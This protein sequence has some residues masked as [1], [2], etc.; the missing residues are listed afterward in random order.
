LGVALRL[1]NV[2]TRT[3]EE[4]RPR[5]PGHVGVYV[6]G[7]TVYDHMHIGHARTAVSF[8]VARRWLE[9]R[10]PKVTFV[11]NVTDVD[12]KILARAKEQGISP[13]QHAAAWDAE[14]LAQTRRL[15]VRDPDHMPHVTTSIPGI[16]RFIQGI[17]ASGFAYATPQHNVYF[18]VPGYDAHAQVHLK[19]AQGRG[20]GY[21]SLSNRDF[22]EMAAGTRK[23]VESD[24]RHPADF[25]LW[26]SADAGDHPDGNWDS[27]WG[28]GRPGWHIECSFMSTDLLGDT[29]DLHGGGQDLVFPHHEN[30]IAQTQA[31]TGKAPFVNVW[32][33]SGFLNVEGEKMSKSLGNFI[34]LRQM[35]DDL[36]AKGGDPE[37]LRFYYVQTHYRSK[38]DF[39]RAG[40]EDATRAL[41]GLHRTREALHVRSQAT[42]L[43]CAD[44][45]VPLQAAAEKLRQDFSASMDDDLHTPGAL[46]ALFAFQR[47]ANR[48]LDAQTATMPLGNAAAKAALAAFE[49]CGQALTL[50]LAPVAAASADVPD[51]L[52][53]AAAS[54]GVPLD[55][56]AS[57]AAA[58]DLF[59]AARGAARTAKDW[60]RS[61]AI[62]D[63]AK[64]A[65]YVIED[66]PAGQRWRRA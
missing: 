14:C 30:E 12:D 26:K 24:K 23:E 56:A 17:L 1:Y 27:P 2:R 3:K 7:L 54:V 64:A 36:Q 38:I 60:K 42:G 18:D 66:T 49:E 58:M 43:G 46:A 22:R 32:M 15:G 41:K 57:D 37:A 48:L 39:S 61:D 44:L 6:C 53:A 9:R 16:V 51:S 10:F 33:H 40:L 21:G 19:D 45:D 55:G 62:R 20:C 29:I 50:F 13:R 25:V 65:G 11:Q 31:K 5:D 52:R 63:A 4:F 8:E 28:R 47:E 59:V 34:P 35:L